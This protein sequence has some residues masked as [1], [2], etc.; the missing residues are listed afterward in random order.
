MSADVSVDHDERRQPLAT[1]RA[2]EA[3][4]AIHGT[5]T[6][7]LLDRFGVRY[8]AII[9]VIITCP[10]S[11]IALLRA[12]DHLLATSCIVSILV[13]WNLFYSLR[14]VR[15]GPGGLLIFVDVLVVSALCLSLPWMGALEQGNVGWLRLFV[16][17]MCIAYQWYTE[18]GLA[19]LRRRPRPGR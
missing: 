4:S 2:S 18:S 19:W 5:E 6:R 15:G 3:G 7:A 13:V 16:S 11:V 10:T 14:L 12:G 1:G 9:R 17:F 8:A